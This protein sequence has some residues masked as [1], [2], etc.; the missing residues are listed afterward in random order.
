MT[1]ND[2][3]QLA[4]R[5]AE[6]EF[7][8]FDNPWNATQLRSEL[9]QKQSLRLLMDSSGEILDPTR[10]PP[11]PDGLVAYLLVR[12]LPEHEEVEIMRIGVLTEHRGQGLA[13]KLMRR[14]D[15]EL[16]KRLM[17][18]GR[19]NLHIT[20]EVGETNLAA[21]ELYKSCD[22]REISRRK[23]YYQDGTDAIIMGKNFQGTESEEQ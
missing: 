8:C 23:S 9:C 19:E 5:L 15:L 14:L 21:L 1:G 18:G 22:Y 11:N 12:F 17:A 20:L 6:L 4:F 16:K 3:D 7:Q 13:R 2:R 10:W